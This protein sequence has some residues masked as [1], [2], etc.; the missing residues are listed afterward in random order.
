MEVIAAAIAIMVG[1]AF[2]VFSKPIGELKARQSERDV[3]AQAPEH[4]DIAFRVVTIVIG[5]GFIAV[6]LTRLCR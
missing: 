2:I 1:T 6:A 3:G 4:A 5:V